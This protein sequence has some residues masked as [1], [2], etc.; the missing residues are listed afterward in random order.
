M[1][2]ISTYY[3]KYETLRMCP[4][5]NVGSRLSYAY[6]GVKGCIVG[7]ENYTYGFGT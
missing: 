4:V 7:L 5:R 6:K 3:H 1:F 2:C